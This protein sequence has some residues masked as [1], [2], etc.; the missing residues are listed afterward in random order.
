MKNNVN[1]SSEIKKLEFFNIFELFIRKSLTRRTER[2]RT[3]LERLRLPPE[4]QS[5][6]IAVAAPQSLVSA[7]GVDTDAS[8]FIHWSRNSRWIGA[9]Y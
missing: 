3:D 9:H 5:R 1:I 2:Y 7:M 6:D 8:G 4:W